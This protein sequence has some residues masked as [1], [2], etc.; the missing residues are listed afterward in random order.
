M[1]IFWLMCNDLKIFM[2]EKGW[3]TD[4]FVLAFNTRYPADKITVSAVTSWRN[5]TRNP[6]LRTLQLLDEFTGGR[7]NSRSFYVNTEPAPD[8]R[9]H[10][11]P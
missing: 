4:D 3:Q 7:V 1:T 6:R 2:I 11:P 9:A 8:S 10:S 5:M